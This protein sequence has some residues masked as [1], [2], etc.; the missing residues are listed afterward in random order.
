MN[1]REQENHWPGYVDALSNMVL[2]LIFV[3]LVL[4]LSLSLYSVISARQVAEELYLSR[5]DAPG[6]DQSD[7][8]EDRDAPVAD[9]SLESDVSETL[10][11]V[12]EEELDAAS[13][14][15]GAVTPP[16]RSADLEFSRG[17]AASLQDGQS[18]A[19]AGSSRDSGPEDMARIEELAAGI[20]AALADL[21]RR[22]APAPNSPSLGT[23]DEPT[24]EASA[25]PLGSA[26]EAPLLAGTVDETAALPEAAALATTDLE[27]T[28][29]EA[30]DRA[31]RLAARLAPTAPESLEAPHG[32]VSVSSA[33]LPREPETQVTPPS[34][35]A[36][37]AVSGLEDQMIG[38]EGD[39]TVSLAQSGPQTVIAT[40]SARHGQL[41]LSSGS[42]VRIEALDARTLMA[43]GSAESLNRAL[44]G[45]T[46]LGEADFFGTDVLELRIRADE[47][48]P[49]VLKTR[50][51]I[52]P[53]NDPPE[54]LE[55][56]VTAIEDMEHVFR[57]G[58]FRFSDVER[59]PLAAV[60]LDTLPREG[61]LLLADVPLARGAQVSREALD[62]GQ[63]RYR[64]PGD[65]HGEDVATFL[66]RVIDGGGRENEGQDTSPEP[67]MMRLS[68]SATPDAPRLLMPPSLVITE[69]MP[70]P[71]TGADR[72]A[73]SDVDGD[74]A[75]VSIAVQNGTLALTPQ[76]GLE[77]DGQERA[78]ITLRGPEQS[79]NSALASLVVTASPDYF[80][81]DLMTF[82]ATDA[83]GASM[84]SVAPMTVRPVNDPP[85][86]LDSQM[87]ALIGMPV[88][89][90]PSDFDYSDIE[91]HALAAIRIDSEAVFGRLELSGEAVRPGERV[92]IREIETGALVFLPEAP[93]TPET[94]PGFSFTAIDVGG[95]EDGG[96]DISDVSSRMA[97]RSLVPEALAEAS[98]G[99]TGS[100]EEERE[101]QVSE[102]PAA[103]DM[104]A[105]SDDA[106]DRTAEG[107]EADAALIEDISASDVAEAG[108]A[109]RTGNSLSEEIRLEPVEEVVPEGVTPA[110]TDGVAG[111]IV[112]V[113]PDRIVALDAPNKLL[114]A[115]RLSG[116]GSPETLSLTLHVLSPQPNLSVERSAAVT[117]AVSLRQALSEIGVAPEKIRIRIERDLRSARFGE[118]HIVQ[119]S[120]EDSATP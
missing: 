95:R 116:L 32:E 25:E 36:P 110:F 90:D 16:P 114:L 48:P 79:I 54:A 69:D 18:P 109:A 31:G 76:D 93:G 91:N 42:G 85:V 12:L 70:H 64:P 77:V 67:A 81:Q 83:S 29:Q 20:V 120:P 49:L 78:T 60:V 21:D 86:S 13:F 92:D 101:G 102:A 68:L 5:I 72:L 19:G 61:T 103:A 97:I 59:H 34:A 39:Q 1:D 46:Y 74:I 2:A 104:A 37:E 33:E 66:F 7:R 17:P 118:I 89:L 11:G 98:A 26:L 107:S 63:L 14:T 84:V 88:P 75:T 112:I 99:V 115:Q 43:T 22:T 45:L 65:A 62:A 24:A 47:G 94:L 27:T 108:A 10:S 15:G 56:P 58:D 8:L 35:T 82:T 71:M 30:L 96:V 3:V 55:S 28:L 52:L 40:L 80:G 41:A 6:R 9:Q 50:I 57:P 106:T 117:R 44:L 53:V 113:F 73:V 51:D 4:A 100:L 87:T 119:T 23:L 38:F 105:A 111:Q